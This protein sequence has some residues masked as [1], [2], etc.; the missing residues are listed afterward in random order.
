MGGAA[1]CARPRYAALDGAVA[2]LDAAGEGER[3]VTQD[4]TADLAA[5]K[6][7]LDGGSATTQAEIANRLEGQGARLR[8]NIA[9]S[10]RLAAEHRARR[11]ARRVRQ[12]R[13]AGRRGAAY[14]RAVQTYEDDRAD[15][16]RALV[17]LILGF[18]ARPRFA[19]RT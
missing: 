18:D 8:A 14:N 12:R 6:A 15:T 11:C 3:A 17:A 9:G 19:A 5:W 10:A 4:L 13:A 16:R 1:R 2:A 7:A